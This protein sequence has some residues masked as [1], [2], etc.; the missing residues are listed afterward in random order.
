MPERA[1][2]ARSF[3][4]IT[5]ID[6]PPL[7]SSSIPV[8]KFAFTY[9][10]PRSSVGYSRALLENFRGNKIAE[11]AVLLPR[12]KRKRRD[13]RVPEPNQLARFER[14]VLPHLDA[15]YNLARWLTRNDHD[16]EDVVQEAYLRA[17]KFFGGFRGGD[18]R[19]WLLAIV[20]N[21][22]YTWIEQNRKHEMM[23][24]FDEEAHD[25]ESN[26][27]NPET[28]LLQ[29]ADQQMLKQALEA[30]PVEFR[31]VVILRELEGL[32][33]KEIADLAH[34]PLGTVMSRLARARKRLQQD[35]TERIRKGAL[36]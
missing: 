25:V 12:E 14:A 15:A 16:A 5:T 32:S 7:S 34:L 18:S 22:C 4:P 33:Y 8:G 27:P 6:L 11:R 20:R 23:T 9:R 10:R 35:L 24:D 21:T 2:W 13:Q 17:L 26:D 1:V 29:S 19:A 31:E 3:M 30:L 28:A 36:G